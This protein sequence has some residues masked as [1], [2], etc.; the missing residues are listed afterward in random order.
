VRG[1][2]GE[3]VAGNREVTR[4]GDT[5][6]LERE[7]QTSTGASR[8]VSKEVEFDEGRVEEIER[9]SETTGRYGETIEREAEIERDRY[10]RVEFEG[11]ARTSTGRRAEVE[12]V[13][14]VGPYGR[15][16]VVADVDTRYRGDWTVAAGR[17]PYG[18]AVT[19]LPQG[20]R[21]YTYHGRPYYYHGSAYYRPYTWRGMPY[22]FVVPPP[23]GVVYTSVPP[24]AVVLAVAGLT[25]YFVDHVAYKQ[26]HSDGSVGYEVT[27]TP[28]GLE[29]TSLPPERA[30]VTIGETTYFYYKNTFYREVIEE[31]AV[32]YVVV[33]DPPGLEIVQALPAEFEIVQ[34]ASG[35]SY[36]SAQG[37]YY[38]PYVGANGQEAYVAV[39]PLQTTSTPQTQPVEGTD[40]VERSLT[41]PA[42]TKLSV[43]IAD[44]LSS[45]T[46]QPGQRFTSYL[47]TELRVGEI[48]AVPRGSAVHGRVVAVE[49]AG[50]MSGT[51]SLTLTVTD[52]E[53]GGDVI[54]V[55]SSHYVVEGSSSSSDTG[56]KI[57]GGAGLGALIG[58]I[59][60]G[61][62]GA[63][64]GAAVG[65][66]VGTAA[67]AATKGQQAEIASQTPLAFTLE[68]PLTIPIAVRVA[69]A[70]DND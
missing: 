48:L 28:S 13:A 45:E 23:Y 47:D 65:A 40:V 2:R 25:Y 9:S 38:L 35:A 29:T 22:Y 54:P 64:I 27:P 39:D 53:V 16:G 61:G 51:S 59:A 30:T 12:G 68:Q 24:G 18:A 21:P 67:S 6:R 57:V 55:L 11:E 56:R 37:T 66:G 14:G 52:M 3:T 44:E 60:D 10:G 41:L 62:S 19:R 50:N 17:G 33:T 69:R 58:A 34:A 8:E 26:T 42:K 31:G 36:F 15:R 32:R 20:Y 5:L 4:E 1:R 49:E 46:A 7:V 43:R 70:E 63:A